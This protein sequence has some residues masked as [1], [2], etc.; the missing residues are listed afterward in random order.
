[1]RESGLWEPKGGLQTGVGW[2]NRVMGI[3]EGTCGDEHWVLYESLNTT[4]T[5]NVVLIYWLVEHNF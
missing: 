3:K 4:S 2:G 5:A 1:M